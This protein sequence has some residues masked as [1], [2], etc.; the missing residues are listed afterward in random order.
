MFKKKYFGVILSLF[1][2]CIGLNLNLESLSL[3]LQLA[4][5]SYFRY[6][7]LYIASIYYFEKQTPPCSWSF[8]RPNSFHWG[9]QIE[10]LDTKKTHSP[11]DVRKHCGK[12][13]K[14]WRCV[15][16]LEWH[17]VQVYKRE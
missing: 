1:L 16:G 3:I 5:V 8:C 10:G 14:T 13:P 7:K 15:E 12:Y 9:Q 2:T 4:D 17:R 6:F 11:G